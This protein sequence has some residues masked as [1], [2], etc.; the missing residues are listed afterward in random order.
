MITKVNSLPEV[1]EVVPSMI[2]DVVK[3]EPKHPVYLQTNT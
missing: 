2:L 1:G 3:E